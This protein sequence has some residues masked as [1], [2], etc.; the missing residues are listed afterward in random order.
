MPT[1]ILLAKGVLLNVYPLCD[2]AAS[3]VK[4]RENE[5][6]FDTPNYSVFIT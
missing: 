6:Q 1:V 2:V 3:A 5:Q 4:V